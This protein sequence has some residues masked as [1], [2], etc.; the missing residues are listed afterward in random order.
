MLCALAASAQT[1]ASV[2]IVV[3]RNDP[4][5]AQVAEYYRP[6]RG[7]PAGNICYLSTASQE[8]IAFDVY[9]REIQR[10]IADCLSHGDL[11]ESILYIVL[12]MGVP[13][14]VEGGGS[15]FTAEYAS[16]DSELALLYGKLK[17]AKFARA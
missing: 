10:P 17:G 16:V 15:R 1:G 8:E 3:N 12:T 5:S 14:K 11:R 2:L 7:V 4:V 6:R 13:L 9:E